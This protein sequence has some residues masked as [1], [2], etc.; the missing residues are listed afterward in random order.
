MVEEAAYGLLAAGLGF[1]LLVGAFAPA[2]RRSRRRSA[3]RRRTPRPV[4]TPAPMPLPRIERGPSTPAKVH[5][6]LGELAL[7]ARDREKALEHFRKALAL[8]PSLGLRRT[9]EK[10]QAPPTLRRVA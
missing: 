6:M 5:V 9:V 3:R 8:D 7:Q 2:W 1:A 4:A 10:L